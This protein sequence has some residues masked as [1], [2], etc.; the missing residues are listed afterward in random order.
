MLNSQGH[1]TLVSHQ[2]VF[3]NSLHSFFYLYTCNILNSVTFHSLSTFKTSHIASQS[4][5][6]YVFSRCVNAAF[7][8]FFFADI[9]IIVIFILI[10][11]TLLSSK[12]TPFLTNF[13]LHHFLYC[14]YFT[15]HFV[16][17]AQETNF[18]LIT[19]FILILFFYVDLESSCLCWV[20]RHL[21]LPQNSFNYDIH[22]VNYS[23]SYVLQ[24]L[25]CYF[26][27]LMLS[28][29]LDS[30]PLAASSLGMSLCSY[31]LP[32]LFTLMHVCCFSWF[33]S[34]FSYNSL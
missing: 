18:S 9:L 7:K 14:K 22:L 12:L 2:L 26:L 25:T 31:I 30:W 27:C 3:W 1:I 8:L 28:H 15:V 19:I 32:S 33:W 21:P 16:R 11:T 5:L 20:F 23:L 10:Y 29:T 4:V 24:H 17:Y 34:S 13:V 6:S